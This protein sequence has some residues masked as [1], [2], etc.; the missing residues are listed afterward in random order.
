MNEISEIQVWL[1]GLIV[2]VVVY[3]INFWQRK[4]GTVISW[5]VLTVGLYVIALIMTVALGTFQ[6][7]VFPALP[8]FPQYPTGRLAGSPT[9]LRGICGYWN[10]NDRR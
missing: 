10:P 5:Q 4:R 3:M 9:D 1:I 7:P 2:S 6:W 8:V